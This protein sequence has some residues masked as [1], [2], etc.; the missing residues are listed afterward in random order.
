[1]KRNILKL[2]LPWLLSL[3]IL[4][5]I[6]NPAYAEKISVNLNGKPLSFDVSPTMHNGRVLV[7]LRIIFESLGAT[8]DWDGI[9]NTVTASKFGHVVK[10]KIGERKA[11]IGNSTVEIDV[12]PIVINNRTLV[13]VRFVSEAFGS[14]VTWNEKDKEVVILSYPQP[15]SDI[16]EDSTLKFMGFVRPEIKEISINVKKDNRFEGSY[17]YRGLAENGKVDTI[18]YLPLGPGSY[19]IQVSEKESEQVF[20]DGT[21]MESFS[22]TQS[23][24]IKNL[25]QRIDM[26]Y[27]FPSELV[28]SDSPE[29]VELVSKITYGLETDME[30]TKAIHDWVASNIAYNLDM[31]SRGKATNALKAKNGVCQDYSVLNAALHRAAGIKAKVVVGKSIHTSQGET[32]QNSTGQDHAWNEIFVDGRWIIQDTTWDAGSVDLTKK[33]FYPGLKHKYFDPDPAIFE[34]DHKKEK[35]EEYL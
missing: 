1:M 3:F 33:I 9:T 34:Q 10:L 15:I 35:D 6:A 29:I 20:N 27:L 26:R 7:P 5:I 24:T 13:P 21:V 14:Y 28:D 22:P 19:T 25:D 8:V 31:S 18:I 17:T 30:K 2:Y 23:Y 11:F 32:W 4:I 16:S 12:P